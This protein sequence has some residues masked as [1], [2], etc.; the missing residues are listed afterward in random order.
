MKNKL[1]I[2]LITYNRADN[3]KFTLEQIFADNSPIKDFDITILDNASTDGTDKIIEDYQQR[4]G[5]IKYI[6]HKINCGGNVNICK[7]Y[8]MAATCGKEYAWV[9]CDDDVYDFSDWQK[10]VELIEKG[11]DIICVSNFMIPQ[12]E[13]ENYAYI[14]PQLTFVP[15][16]IFKTK[17][18][19]AET[20]FAMYESTYTMLAQLCPVIQTVNNNG[21]IK[22]I[23]NPIVNNGMHYGC[24]DEN[25]SYTRDF[26]G[27]HLPDRLIKRN[28]ILGFAEITNFLK[29]KELQLNCVE[30]GIK[31]KRVYGKW[32]MFHFRLCQ[33]YFKSPN[34][35]Y[36][37]EVYK[38]LKPLRKLQFW[39]YLILNKLCI[40]RFFKMIKTMKKTFGFMKI[41]NQAD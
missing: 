18:L 38:C 20:M 7:A 16:C 33:I 40:V 28:W 11:T 19:T 34:L 1:G 8:E 10:V 27:N 25:S 14:I 30:N 17:I 13:L 23:K 2:Y 35:N 26:N 22:T 31:Y 41:I 39:I 4:F 5:N 24:G 37:Y 12:N 3:L 15:A 29:D 6:R 9:L 21:T 32:S 36:F